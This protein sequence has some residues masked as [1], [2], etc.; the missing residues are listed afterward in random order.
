M[1]LLYNGALSIT[2]GS[3]IGLQFDVGECV[4]V[5]LSEDGLHVGI[6]K[7]TNG[8]KVRGGNGRGKHICLGRLVNVVVD[9]DGRSFTCETMHDPDEQTWW[10]AIPDGLRIEG[11]P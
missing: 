4:A 9:G 8:Y 7:R 11:R 1:S 5:C 3:E 2:L 6:K 10:F